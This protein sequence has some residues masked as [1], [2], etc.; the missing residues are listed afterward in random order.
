MDLK[1]L[2]ETKNLRLTK[3]YN[4]DKVLFGSGWSFNSHVHND[5]DKALVYTVWIQTN[6]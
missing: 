3:I 5:V 6:K 4:Q 1:I 2:N